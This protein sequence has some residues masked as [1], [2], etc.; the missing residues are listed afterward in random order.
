[1]AN[2]TKASAG[3]YLEQPGFDSDTYS[4]VNES[5][6]ENFEGK[7]T[8]VCPNPKCKRKFRIPKASRALQIICPQCKNL[9]NIH[10][11]ILISMNY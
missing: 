5:V 6:E 11:Y 1:M 10:K 7:I 9:L 8:I 2:D 4:L 3:S